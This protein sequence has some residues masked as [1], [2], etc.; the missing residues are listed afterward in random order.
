MSTLVLRKLVPVVIVD[1]IEPLLTFYVDQLGFTKAVEAPHGDAL[2]FVM[3]VHGELELMFQTTSSAQADLKSHALRASP[4]CLYLDVASLDDVI[5]AVKEAP[6]VV[7][8]RTAPHGADEIFVRDPASN[9][10]GFAAPPAT[11]AA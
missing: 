1:R 7:P 2:G 8:R 10:V 5:A 6:V 11:P 3:L 4:V 9:I